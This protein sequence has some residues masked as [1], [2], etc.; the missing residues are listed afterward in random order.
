[1]LLRS[2][3][4]DLP[5]AGW[6][7]LASVSVWTSFLVDDF[8]VVVDF[9]SI[10]LLW[11]S[12][13]VFEDG[14]VAGVFLTAGEEAVELDQARLVVSF[15]VSPFSKGDVDGLFPLGGFGEKPEAKVSE[16]AVDEAFALQRPIISGLGADPHMWDVELE[17]VVGHFGS[18]PRTTEMLLDPEDEILVII[19][20]VGVGHELLVGGRHV[21]RLR[22]S[23]KK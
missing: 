5:E 7:I 20:K 12:E 16:H 15:A 3:E 19:L 17:A 23:G 1:M 13:E 11:W 4:V 22:R 10:G 18:F 2:P 14:D 21:G 9:A 6:F 8:Q